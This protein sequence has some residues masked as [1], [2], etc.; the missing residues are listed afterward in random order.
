MTRQ[1]LPLPAEGEVTRQ[2]PQSGLHHL[3]PI[4]NTGQKG[5]HEAAL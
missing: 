2:K 4:G 3:I 1:E 5:P